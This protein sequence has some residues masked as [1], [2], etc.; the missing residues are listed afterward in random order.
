MKTYSIDDINKA[1]Q[2]L[3]IKVGD[4]L[5]VHS[6]LFNLGKIRDYEIAEIPGLFVQILLKHVGKEGTIV[7]PTFN[8]DFCEG[9][10]FNRQQS[11]SKNMG[12]L[13]EYIRLLP[14][15]YRSSHP[16]QSVATI[17]RLAEK[18]CAPDTASSFNEEGPYSI[19]L[20]NNA[21]LLLIGASIQS[22]SLI[23]YAEE[24]AKVPYR[25]WENFE[26]KYIDTSGER[27]ETYKMYVRDLNS[28]PVLDLSK[29]ENWLI[30]NDKLK[31]SKLGSGHIKIC[32]C[33]DFVS[34]T[35]S[36]LKDNPYCLL[37]T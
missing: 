31:I 28:N 18:I 8:F 33:T 34:I 9:K 15:S 26:G 11:P 32:N 7:V 5:L 21:K 6:S 36:R 20:N 37:K 35:I 25:Y 13:A 2:C 22:A 24:R 27:V 3:G 1:F 14:N 4:S 12:V 29:I 16:M 10:P 19:M 17:G 23:H 30:E